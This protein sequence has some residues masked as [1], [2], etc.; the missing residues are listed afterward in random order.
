[1]N[2]REKFFYTKASEAL[3]QVAQIG[4]GY[5]ICRDTQGEAGWGSEQSDVV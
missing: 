2:I 3:A 4:G 5:P 1:M